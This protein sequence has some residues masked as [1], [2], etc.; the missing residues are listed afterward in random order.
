[1]I[2]VTPPVFAPFAAWLWCAVRRRNLIVDCHPPDAF[3]AARWAWATSLHRFL[4]RRAGLVLCHTQDNLDVACSWGAR[5]ELLIDDVP[6]PAQADPGAATSGAQI[7]VAGAFSGNEPVREALAAAARLPGVRF[8]FTG[9]PALLPPEVRENVPPNVVLTGYLP[10]AQFLAELR[11]AAAVAVFSG[12]PHIFT[13]RAAF[14][15]VGMGRPLVLLDLRGVRATFGDAALYTEARPAEMAKVFSQALAEQPDLGARSEAKAAE[16]RAR[17][18]I[19]LEALL[20]HLDRPRSRVRQGA[21]PRALVLSQHSFVRRVTAQRNV[22]ELARQGY[23]VDVVCTEPIPSHVIPQD[24]ADR[25]RSYS[26]RLE[27]R[28]DSLPRYLYEYSVFLLWALGWST[29]LGLRHRY[30]VVVADNIPD[31]LALAAPVPRAR[32]SRLVFN[33]FELMPEMLSARLSGR[34]ARI[35]RRVAQTIERLAIKAA[36]E[37]IVVSEPCRQVLLSRNVPERKLHVVVNTVDPPTGLRPA[38]DAG[39]G[40]G[41]YLV[42][43]GSLLPRYGTHVAVEALARLRCAWPD[44]R[45]QVIGSGEEL[46]RLRRLAEELGVADRVDFPGNLPWNEVQRRIAHARVGIVALVPDS[47]GELLLPTKLLE[48]AAVSTPAVCSRQPA[49]EAYFPE[50][51][52]LYVTP[53]SVDELASGISRLL[54]KPEQAAE[55]ASRA[56][57]VIST[58]SWQS[59]RRNFLRAVGVPG[60]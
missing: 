28:R 18:R 39:A 51:A 57:E 45:L 52:V 60:R 27:H 4:L 37:V 8:A 25:I 33:M 1:M 3:D 44:L 5:A 9:D 26:L 12:D 38:V 53:G 43:H 31:V 41:P 30:D 56:R 35:V 34:P 50:D 49:I 48:L 20:A 46:P 24:C 19:G 22:V 16:L 59:Q 29:R 23:D 42:T 14:E 2:A 40:E 55:L 58:I 32:G 10:Y 6:S 7:V 17:R 47:Y 21:R 15:A 13:P 36:D 11:A 54:S